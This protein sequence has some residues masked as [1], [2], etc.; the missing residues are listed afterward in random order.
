MSKTIQI[1][2]PEGVS[3]QDV[4]IEFV[5]KPKPKLWQPVMG[6][7]YYLID[8][9]GE[10]L[11]ST[12]YVSG[13]KR[14]EMHPRRV[15]NY[16]AYP[17]RKLVDKAA[18]YLAPYRMLV[19]TAL[20]VDPEFEPDWYDASQKKFCL[21]KIEGNWAIDSFL[22]LDYHAPVVSTEKKAEQ[23]LELVK[24]EEAER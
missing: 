11:L 14:I 2:L 24:A 20:E 21:Y 9:D 12:Y 13:G 8:S 18:D 17:S 6:D 22:S 3:E 5:A 15:D 4:K 7:E 1:E 10:I 23:W 16:N 19:R